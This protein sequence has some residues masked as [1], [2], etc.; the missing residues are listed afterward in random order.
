MLIS[1]LVARC[2]FIFHMLPHCYGL[3]ACPLLSRA[4][5]WEFK[6]P[7]HI[8][9]VDGRTLLIIVIQLVLPENYSFEQIEREKFSCI[10]FLG[11]MLYGVCYVYK[12]KMLPNETSR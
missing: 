2:K 6:I 9:I 3:V 8:V 7:P 10:V 4:R 5:G 11:I 12:S 1:L